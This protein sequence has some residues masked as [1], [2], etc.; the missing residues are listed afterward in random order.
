MAQ[1]FR[2]EFI[3]RIDDVVVFRPLAHEDIER[4]ADL[5]LDLL[6]HR[7]A[8]QDLSLTLSP[9]TMETLC[10]AGYDPVYGARPLKRAIQRMVENP[11]AEAL[12]SQGYEAGAKLYGDWEADGLK[13]FEVSK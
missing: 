11:L 6:N 4:I 3:N 9:K 8:D 12:L 13:I 5:Q 10:E 7:L 1:H 2:P